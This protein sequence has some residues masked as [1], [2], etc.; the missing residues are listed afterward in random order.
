[1]YDTIQQ[2]LILSHTELKNIY[3]ESVTNEI[4]STKESEKVEQGINIFIEWLRSGK[5]E[6]RAYP[7]EKIHAKVY[8]MSFYE[9][10]RD[11][12]RVIT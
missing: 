10:D 4:E 7:T 9:D 3:S 6:I 12:G 11:V 1:M 2:A 8:I 5:L